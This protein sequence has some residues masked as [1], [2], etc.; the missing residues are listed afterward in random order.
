MTHWL[1][2]KPCAETAS[3]LLGGRVSIEE[4]AISGGAEDFPFEQRLDRSAA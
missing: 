4:C 2:E 3:T 1:I